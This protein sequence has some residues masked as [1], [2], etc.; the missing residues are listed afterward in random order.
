[1]ELS[2]AMKVNGVVMISLPG[3]RP[4]ARSASWMANVPLATAT[5]CGKPDHAAKSRSNR[6]TSGPLCVITPDSHTPAR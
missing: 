4:S 2:V 6:C 5:I 1:M 3:G